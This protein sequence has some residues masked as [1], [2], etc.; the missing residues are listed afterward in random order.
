MHPYALISAINDVIDE[1]TVTILDGGDI[2][3]FGRVALKVTRGYLDPG[4][5]GC[6]G[7]GVPFANAAAI[8]LPGRCVVA[9]IGD[10]AFGFL[11]IELDT[12]VRHNAR[13]VYVI[14]NNEGWNIDRHDQLRNYQN[15]VGVALPGCRYDQVAR[16]L[17]AHGERVEKASD[18]P[19]AL[20]RAIANAPAVVDVLV[21]AEPTSPDF[22]SGLAEVCTLQALKKW[23]DA[24]EAPPRN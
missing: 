19:G 14:A 15:V 21:S 8:N 1:E 20:R 16:G 3:S 5:L 12:A 22:D 23:N 9:L 4:P 18:L 13:A 24:E 17:G 2:L 6:I 10:G 11:A 7:V